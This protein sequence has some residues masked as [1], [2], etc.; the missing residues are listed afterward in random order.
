MRFHGLTEDRIKL[1]RKQMKDK[2]Y[3][4]RALAGAGMQISNWL[5][6]ESSE[7]SHAYLQTALK[8]KE[9]QNA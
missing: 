2:A 1:L 9:K 5:N 6:E 4:S 7:C 8:K 3:M